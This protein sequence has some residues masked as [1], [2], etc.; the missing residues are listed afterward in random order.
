MDQWTT[1]VLLDDVVSVTA[2]L[3]RADETPPLVHLGGPDRLSRAQW[4]LAIA[5]VAG[6]DQDLVVPVPRASG[7][8]ADRPENSCLASRVLAEHPATADVRVRGAFE[9]TRTLFEQAAVA[10][11]AAR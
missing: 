10:E 1:P 2:A 5:E 3:L 9:G 11:E 4:A 8:Y 6:A 7:R